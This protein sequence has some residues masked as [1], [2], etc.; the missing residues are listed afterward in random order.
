MARAGPRTVHWYSDEF[1]IVAHVDERA[2]TPSVVLSARTEDQLAASLPAF[3]A[4]PQSY[5]YV[6]GR[7]PTT[8]PCGG[9]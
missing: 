7:R 3:R 9:A 4:L 8:L 6:A 5:R 1:T 2:V